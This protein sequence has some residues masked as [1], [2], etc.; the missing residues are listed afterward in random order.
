MRAGLEPFV[1]SAGVPTL[2][3]ERRSELNGGRKL[4]SNMAP[5]G[6]YALEGDR[7]LAHIPDDKWAAEAVLR[8]A[9]QVATFRLGGILMHGCG[10]DFGGAGVAAIG[11]S[12]A[13]KSTLSALSS[14]APGNATPA[15]R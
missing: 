10:L 11:H 5:W 14:D 3:V 6:F 1:A 2:F 12:G 9:W 13:G 4:E 8:I 7:V 15:H